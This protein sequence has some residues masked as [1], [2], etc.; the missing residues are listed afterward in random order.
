MNFHTIC[1]SKLK[2]LNIINIFCSKIMY[3]LSPVKYKMTYRVLA[4]N[5]M[6]LL[7]FIHCMFRNSSFYVEG[8]L[9]ERVDV[10]LFICTF[11]VYCIK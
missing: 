3:L 2:M 10:Y 9:E 6:L 8:I 4:H 11:H 5:N 7:Q 1:T